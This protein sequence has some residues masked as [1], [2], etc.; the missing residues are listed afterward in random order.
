MRADVVTA[1]NIGDRAETAAAAFLARNGHVILARNIVTR[2]GE[3]D[4]VSWDR[5]RDTLAFIEVKYRSREDYGRALDA[6]NTA[7]Q[8]RIIRAAQVYLRQ[9]KKR[10]SA[11]RFDVIAVAPDGSVQHVCNAFSVPTEF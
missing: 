10:F 4:I 11:Y 3:L 1:K 9:Q 2:Y 7:K 8:R 5:A 6:V